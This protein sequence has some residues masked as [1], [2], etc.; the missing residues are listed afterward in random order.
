MKIPRKLKKQI[1][2]AEVRFVQSRDNG[3]DKIVKRDGQY[4]LYR[5]QLIKVSNVKR[6]VRDKILHLIHVH[7][8]S[9]VKHDFHSLCRKIESQ[10]A[11][12]GELSERK[13][14]DAYA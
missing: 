14:S 9:K 3:T 11:V 4:F 5:S 6:S 12:A 1:K 2:K 13:R 7:E 10:L 8:K